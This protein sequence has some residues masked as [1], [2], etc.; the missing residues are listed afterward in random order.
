MS[1]SYVQSVTRAFSILELLREHPKGLGV[2][3]IAEKLDL[4][5]TTAHRLVNTLI[6]CKVVEQ[7]GDNRHYRLAPYLLLY[8]KA[9]L[10]RFDFISSSR[11]YLGELSKAV[12]ETVFMGILDD[13]E[14]V[15]VDHVDSLDHALRLTPQ[16][17][18]RHS[19][20]ATALGK[21]LLANLPASVIEVYFS[22]TEQLERLTDNTITD[23]AA[24]RQELA[25]TCQRGYALDNEE[26]ETGICCIAMPVRNVEG[27][28]V[29]AVSISGPATRIRKKG[30]ETE[31]KDELE[32]ALA[33]VSQLTIV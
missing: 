8:S 31:L 14:L 5:T 16:I 20:H 2:S 27:Q 11:P 26:S 12:G 33:K 10:D 21:V 18:R 22:G 32:A 9:V 3:D 15:Y 28:T 24:L 4:S 17:G 23:P 30:L 29:A 7:N 6:A 13:F 1:D 25:L 19:A